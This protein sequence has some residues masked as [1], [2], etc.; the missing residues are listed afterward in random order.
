MGLILQLGNTANWSQVF[1]STVAAYQIG[2]GKYAPIPKIVIPTQL[3]SPILAVYISC[4]PNKPTW[5]FA[6]WLSQSVFTGLTIG[7]VT[8]A[9]NV[10][11]RKIWLNKITLVRLEKLANSYSID[12]EVPKWFESV[13]IQVWE[14]TGTVEDS[15]EQ[16]IR[17]IRENELKRIEQ[18]V[19][20]ISNY[21]GA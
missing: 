6:G 19:D 8:D 9:E 5:K 11:R 18:K 2:N 16:L 14:Y 4:N 7:G 21:G 13:S 17:E 20:D 12:F 1:S 15:T 10:Q 3:E